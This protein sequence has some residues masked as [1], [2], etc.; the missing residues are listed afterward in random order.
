M[1][2]LEA[3]PINESCVPHSSSSG[4]GG[5]LDEDWRNIE[6]KRLISDLNLTA[7][8]YVPFFNATR[9]LYSLHP[10]KD[11]N[12]H[13]D[14]THFCWTPTMWQPLWAA[15]ASAIRQDAYVKASGLKHS[16]SLDGDDFADFYPLLSGKDGSSLGNGSAV[17]NS[18]A[19]V[20]DQAAPS[21][22]VNPYHWVPMQDPRKWY[23][24]SELCVYRRFDANASWRGVLSECGYDPSTRTTVTEDATA[25][26]GNAQVPED[27]CNPPLTGIPDLMKTM[28]GFNR[29]DDT[30]F[31]DALYDLH[32]NNRTLVFLGDSMT[33]QTMTAF[34][35]EVKRLDSTVSTQT[36]KNR[37]R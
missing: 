12:G 2:F 11:A 21:G 1:N 6:A 34:F 15:L 16:A 23:R 5:G 18:T 33:Q 35:A 29:F 28:V 9:D 37:V 22:E 14:C 19:E 4:V 8:R 31:L 26:L 32:L 25:I 13:V 20:I 3:H 30:S 10:G 24:K 17:A 7:L 27:H 36:W